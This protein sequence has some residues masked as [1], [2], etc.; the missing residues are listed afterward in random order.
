MVM[1]MNRGQSFNEFS[2]LIRNQGIS[3]HDPNLDLSFH[4]KDGFGTVGLPL[5]RRDERTGQHSE[6]A[7]G[8]I[9]EFSL[10]S[11]EIDPESRKTLQRLVDLAG[12]DACLTLYSQGYLAWVRHAGRFR[13]RL[14]A[15][16]NA[17]AYY[18][19]LSFRGTEVQLTPDYISACPV[20]IVHVYMFPFTHFSPT[21]SLRYNP[22]FPQA[23]LER[24][25]GY[26]SAT[27][28]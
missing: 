17:F 9:A 3:L 16:W 10:I 1:G 27:D 22:A 20:Y 15:K 14:A 21:T 26:P 5:K 7:R 13:D 4:E 11:Y 12:Q 19:N 2:V 25:R 18:F 28:P 23:S 24:H 8:M 6:F